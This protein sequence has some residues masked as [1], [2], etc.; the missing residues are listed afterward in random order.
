[1]INKKKIIWNIIMNIEKRVDIA[2]LPLVLVFFFLATAC[3]KGL[4]VQVL[5]G[6]GLACHWSKTPQVLSVGVKYAALKYTQ[7]SYFYF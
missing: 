3:E 2:Y 7:N 1:M 4:E 5:L 6:G